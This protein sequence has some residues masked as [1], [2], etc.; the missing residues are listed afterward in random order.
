MT[1][2]RHRCSLRRVGDALVATGALCGV[3]V[4]FGF[5][6]LLPHT[7]VYALFAG[8]GFF[9]AVGFIVQAIAS[10]RSTGRP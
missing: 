9:M 2:F 6:R 4:L 3:L 10:R 8:W 5:G 1:A 7:L